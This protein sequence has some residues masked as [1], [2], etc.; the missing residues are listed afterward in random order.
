[1]LFP[2]IDLAAEQ[3]QPAL[4]STGK[5][6]RRREL[7]SSTKT[8]FSCCSAVVKIK[9]LGMVRSNKD[10]IV[11]RSPCLFVELPVPRSMPSPLLLTRQSPPVSLFV[12]VT[13]SP[14]VVNPRV[15]LARKLHPTNFETWGTEVPHRRREGEN[16]M[17]NPR[18][19]ATGSRMSSILADRSIRAACRTT[20]PEFASSE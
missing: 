19:S 11:P 20:G 13:F 18:R 15:G 2:S 4:S 3:R 12:H 6:F 16:F 7:K 17:T 8:E 1:M 9:C 14:R 10:T 5:L